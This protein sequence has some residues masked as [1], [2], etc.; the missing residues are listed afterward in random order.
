M[1]EH[2]GGNDAL[3]PQPLNI[4][5]GSSESAGWP[6]AGQAERMAHLASTEAAADSFDP[7]QMDAELDALEAGTETPEQR[8][9]R[10][11]RF[12]ETHFA[13]VCP[14]E[15]L[16]MAVAECALYEDDC[17]M[18]FE[19][20]DLM[21][22]D[23]DAADPALKQTIQ[24][25]IVANAVTVSANEAAIT[26]TTTERDQAIATRQEQETVRSWLICGGFGQWRRAKIRH[27]LRMGRAI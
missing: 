26:A 23:A 1:P 18:L 17:R 11:G 8:N 4:G 3:P 22:S 16:E 14:P 5:E 9:Q 12:V 6:P 19:E 25:Q 10:L 13:E 15:H 20:P 21:L 2:I 27:S 24:S 7:S